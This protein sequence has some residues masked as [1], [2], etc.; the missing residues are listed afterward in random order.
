MCKSLPGREIEQRHLARSDL[1]RSRVQ[2]GEEE[3]E[4][5]GVERFGLRRDGEW[6]LSCL[7]MSFLGP[8][9]CQRPTGFNDPLSI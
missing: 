1:R 2:S 3:E 8:L 9:I 4:E 6:W 5:R 7:A